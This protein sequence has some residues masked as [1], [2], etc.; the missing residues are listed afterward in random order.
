MEYRE[1]KCLEKRKLLWPGNVQACE[2]A[3]AKDSPCCTFSEIVAPREHGEN[4]GNA[5]TGALSYLGGGSCN[6]IDDKG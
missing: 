1:D 4:I 2:Q 6:N 3:K 5:Q